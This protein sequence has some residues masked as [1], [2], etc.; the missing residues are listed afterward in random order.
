MYRVTLLRTGI[1][2]LTTTKFQKQSFHNS[3]KHRCKGTVTG[4]PLKSEWNH[5]ETTCMFLTHFT[6]PAPPVECVEIMTHSFTDRWFA[7]G[8]NVFTHICAS[9]W[10]F[11]GE[12]CPPHQLPAPK[13]T[14]SLKWGQ[15]II[16]ELR[17]YLRCH[18]SMLSDSLSQFGLLL[19]I[20]QINVYNKVCV[21]LTAWSIF[22]IW[23]LNY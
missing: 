10:L 8:R 13:K 21:F 9:S 11:S 22:Y 14:K 5:P 18:Y 1:S 20:W 12:R 19:G 3:F 7:Q 15:I 16:L 2:T 6:S 17:A 4:K 23:L